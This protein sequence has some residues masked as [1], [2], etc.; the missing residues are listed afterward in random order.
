VQVRERNPVRGG[1]VARASEWRW[2]SAAGG[3]GTGKPWLTPREGWSTPA[4]ADW[5]EW[6]NAPVNQAELEA[7]RRSVT[8]GATPAKGEGTDD[9]P[10]DSIT[11][12]AASDL[13]A[14]GATATQQNWQ[15]SEQSKSWSNPFYAK[16]K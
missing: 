15:T 13:S 2:S 6:V 14:L 8:R 4:P 7:L 16:P 12:A 11:S 9:I 10:K 5:D 1:L 3:A